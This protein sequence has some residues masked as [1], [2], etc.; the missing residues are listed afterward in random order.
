[1]QKA[2][3]LI[4]RLILYMLAREHY[5]EAFCPILLLSGFNKYIASVFERG[6]FIH[7]KYDSPTFGKS[8]KLLSNLVYLTLWSNIACIGCHV[9]ASLSA[10]HNSV[11]T[12]VKV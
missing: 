1:M 8:Q 4:T 11:N 6:A 10:R 9:T 5:N 3:F 2:G 12:Y 7:S